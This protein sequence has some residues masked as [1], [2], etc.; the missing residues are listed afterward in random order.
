MSD[1]TMCTEHGKRDLPDRAN[2]DGTTLD[3]HALP[4]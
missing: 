3:R 2:N 1:D 4:L